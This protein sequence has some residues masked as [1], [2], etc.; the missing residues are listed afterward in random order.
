MSAS[1][2]MI[3]RRLPLLLLL[4]APAWGAEDVDPDG[5]IAYSNETCTT[6]SHSTLN[7]DPDTPGGD[8][9]DSVDDGTNTLWHLN[10][11]TPTGNPTTTSEGQ[12]FAVYV[13]KCC[14]AGGTN[15]TIS[16]DLYCGGVLVENN[17]TSSVTSE[18]GELITQTFTFGGVCTSDGSDVEVYIDCQRSGG[19]GANRRSCSVDAVEWIADV[20]AAS[21]RSRAHVIGR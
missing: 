13:K 21:T 9:C 12:T 1:Q 18:T 14:V 4:A 17:G 20:A 10:M 16:L 15:P 5:T 7:E 8:W 3:Y 11:A 2:Q 19:S 6:T